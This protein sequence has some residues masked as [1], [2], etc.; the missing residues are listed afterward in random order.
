MNATRPKS[1]IVG[2]GYGANKENLGSTSNRMDGN[3]TSHHRADS[4]TTLFTT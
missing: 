4:K 1:G 3:K 2:Y